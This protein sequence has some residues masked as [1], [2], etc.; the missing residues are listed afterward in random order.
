MEKVDRTEYLLA[1]LLLRTMKDEPQRNKI[2]QLNIAGF[3]NLE[4]ADILQT[5]PAVV[6]QL[7]YMSSKGTASSKKKKKKRS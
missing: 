3:S 5:T 4:I 1:L 7:L 6:S 2:V